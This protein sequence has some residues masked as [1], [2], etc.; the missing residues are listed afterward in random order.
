MNR[1]LLLSA[2][3]SVL[4]AAQAQESAPREEAL[5]AAF[6]LSADLKQMLA[7]PIPTDPDVKRPVAVRRGERG[8]LVLPECKLSA[9]TI[10]KVAKDEVIPI[11]QLWM[12]GV[13]LQIGGDRPAQEKLLSVSVTDHTL[14]LCA[15]G[16]SKAADG[17]LE[18]LIYHKMAAHS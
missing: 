4:S 6:V 12:R 17:K 1:I 14:L 13:G 8:V 5:K 10:A 15:L 11:G 3:M 7:T 2:L 9:A 18:L 16:V